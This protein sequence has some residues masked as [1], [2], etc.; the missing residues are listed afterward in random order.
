MELII[1]KFSISR[2]A[3]TWFRMFG[4]TMWN[5]L[6]FEPFFHSIFFKKSR[7]KTIFQF[8]DILGIVRKPSPSLI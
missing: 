7:L 4:V 6:I 1:G 5:L 3:L 8:G 2:G